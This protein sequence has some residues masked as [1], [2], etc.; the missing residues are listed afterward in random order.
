VTD[1][2]RLRVLL[3]EVA[4]ILE[5]ASESHWSARVRQSSKGATLEEIASWFG[6]MG[7][8]NDLVVQDS[9]DNLRLRAA[10]SEIYDIVRGSLRD[11]N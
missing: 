4:I 9:A 1:Q 6:G 11:S 7:S 2:D 3:V 8:L 5:R 10:A